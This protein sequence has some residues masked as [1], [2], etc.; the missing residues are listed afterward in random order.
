MWLACLM[1]S[2]DTQPGAYI[3]KL[4]EIRKLLIALDAALPS[5][6]AA[7]EAINNDYITD[8]YTDLVEA[9]NNLKS[10]HVYD[11]VFEET[12]R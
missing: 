9:R 7:A 2:E 5:F 11:W 12:E 8:R 1:E 10:S 3:K 6:H 4:A